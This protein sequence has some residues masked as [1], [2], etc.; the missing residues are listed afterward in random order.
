MLLSVLTGAWYTR[1]EEAL[2]SVRCVST[3]PIEVFDRY[4]KHPAG[5]THDMLTN[6]EGPLWAITLNRSHLQEVY[7]CPIHL[8]LCAS[9]IIHF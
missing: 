7:S 4:Q 9:D 2:A 1:S 3:S 6:I 5:N 8:R